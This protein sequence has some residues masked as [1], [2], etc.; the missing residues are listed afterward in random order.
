MDL[1]MASP[2]ADVSVEKRASSY[3]YENIAHQ[4]ISP[5]GPSGYEVFR[6]VKDYGAKGKCAVI[7]E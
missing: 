1:R 7:D 5:H 6:N 4:G 2:R 3:W